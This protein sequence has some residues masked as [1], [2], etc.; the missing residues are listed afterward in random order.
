[1]KFDVRIDGQAR[2][3][4]IERGAQGALRVT[5]S[6][7]DR[8]HGSAR[9]S[10]RS[11]DKVALGARAKAG[12]KHAAPDIAPDIGP[13]IR[14]DAARPIEQEARQNTEHDTEQD[15]R[16]DARQHT[17]QHTAETYTGTERE[18]DAVDLGGGAYSILLDGA[19]FDIQVVPAA[20]NL[21]VLCRG[22]EFHASVRD[23]RAWRRAGAG[24]QEAHGPRQVVAPMP[25]KVVRVL[26]TAGETVALRQGL[27]VVEAMKMQNEI[28][29]PKDGLIDRVFV[30]EGQAVTTGEPLVN[31]V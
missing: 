9:G 12:A 3:V 16:Q 11:G 19:A 10:E 6:G 13:E 31:I 29:A 22:R 15:T 5:V 23:P 7:P 21:A 4:T 27:V 25:G 26:V 2:T 24:V 18:A 17:P 8:D 1:M 30:R 28:R 14:K 20:E